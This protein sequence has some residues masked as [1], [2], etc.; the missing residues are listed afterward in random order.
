MW[1]VEMAVG[2]E[3]PKMIAANRF[4]PNKVNKVTPVD[5][6]GDFSF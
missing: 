4:H 6:H 2:T 1:A 5:I 3:A